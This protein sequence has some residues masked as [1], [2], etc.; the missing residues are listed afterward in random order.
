MQPKATP[1]RTSATTVAKRDRRQTQAPD[2]GARRQTP[3]ARSSMLITH[4]LPLQA[5]VKSQDEDQDPACC[6]LGARGVLGDIKLKSRAPRSVPACLSAIGRTNRQ[7]SIKR[8]LPPPSRPSCPS[9]LQF[10]ASTCRHLSHTAPSQPRCSP[11]PASMAQDSVT[12]CDQHHRGARALALAPQTSIATKTSI[13]SPCTEYGRVSD[14]LVAM[15][16]GKPSNAHGCKSRLERFANVYST[17]IKV[18]LQ[19]MA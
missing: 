5:N 9:H 14:W 3:D 13:D 17:Y 6:I 15:A 4:R 1:R 18:E 16:T 2:A 12:P 7:W 11:T 8:S 10:S 19:H